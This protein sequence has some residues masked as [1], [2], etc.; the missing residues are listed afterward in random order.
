MC[1]DDM[2][3]GRAEEWKLLYMENEHWSLVDALPYIDTHLDGSTEVRDRV[4]S[5]IEEEMAFFEPRD[6]LKSMPEPELPL[7]NSEVMRQ[8]MARLEAGIPLQAVDLAR[9]KVEQP[10][11]MCTQDHGAWRKAAEAA[12]L[13]L[14]YSRL[15]LANLDL[16]ERWGSKAWIT[17]AEQV[18]AAERCLS[19]EAAALRAQKEDVNKKRKLDQISCGNELRKLVRELEQYQQDN[20]EVESGLTDLD[21][22]VSRLKRF[23]VERNVRIDDVDPSGPPSLNRAAE[24][25]GS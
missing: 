22:E 1:L 19:A 21:E 4:K 18:K 12:H 16:L 11:G 23:A 9:Y 3:S 20:R 5:L 24:E 7:L 8:E 10:Q 2:E 15:R 14:E 17:H 13:Q 6:Y 25:V